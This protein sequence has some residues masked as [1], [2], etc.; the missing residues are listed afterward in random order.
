[1]NKYP[2]IVAIATPLMKCAIHVIRISG[3]DCYE[4]VNKVTSKKIKKDGYTIQHVNI[5]DHYKVV[6]DVSI[7]SKQNCWIT[8]Y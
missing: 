3:S 6:D 8:S 4:I 2:T 5:Y 7:Y 1:M